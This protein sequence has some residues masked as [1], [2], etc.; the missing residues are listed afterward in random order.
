MDF[1]R[2]IGSPSVRIGSV[3]LAA[4]CAASIGVHTFV[5]VLAGVLAALGF[6]LSFR[7]VYDAWMRLAPRIQTV[8]TTLLFGT[9]YL[10]IVPI[11]A[12]FVRMSDPLRLRPRDGESSWIAERRDA[13]D[14][15][16]YQRMG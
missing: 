4:L 16:S 2:L 10:V 11:F 5:A 6:I 9:C 1:E 8:V 3:L 14:V 13:S 15:R 12:V 7:P